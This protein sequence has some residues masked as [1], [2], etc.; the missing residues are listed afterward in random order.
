MSR[1]SKVHL[2]IQSS[3][4]LFMHAGTYFAGPLAIPRACYAVTYNKL[5]G[6]AKTFIVYMCKLYI[7]KKEL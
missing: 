7:G 2:A 5:L 3:V 4:L 6:H 1:L